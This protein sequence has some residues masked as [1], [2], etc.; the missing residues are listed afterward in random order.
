MTIG[1]LTLNTEKS[2]IP[3]QAGIRNK[4]S[5]FLGLACQRTS[6]DAT[7]IAKAA[8]CGQEARNALSHRRKL[9]LIT[10]THKILFVLL[11]I[12]EIAYFFIAS[13][14]KRSA[15]KRNHKI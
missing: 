11:K 3:A 1:N 10:D 7:A 8:A 6:S 4:T 14:S 13:Y 2:D 5:G 9:Y 12:K 15:V